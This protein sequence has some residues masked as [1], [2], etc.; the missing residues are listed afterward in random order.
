MNLVVGTVTQSNEVFIVLS[1]GMKWS[2]RR[3]HLLRRF[4][5]SF[6]ALALQDLSAG[7]IEIPNPVVTPTA[8]SLVYILCEEEADFTPYLSELIL[9][10]KGLEAASRYLLIPELMLFTNPKIVSML[11]G[12]TYQE[13]RQPTQRKTIRSAGG[14]EYTQYFDYILPFYPKDELAQVFFEA[15]FA[16]QIWT[17]QYLLDHLDPS[18]LEYREDGTHTNISL[19]GIRRN[20]LKMDAPHALIYACGAGYAEIVQLLIKFGLRDSERGTCLRTASCLDKIQVVKVLLT[21]LTYDSQCIY[22][23]LRFLFKDGLRDTDK[24]DIL[25]LILGMTPDPV[26]NQFIWDH[27]LPKSFPPR[28][29]KDQIEQLLKFYE[30]DNL[31]VYDAYDELH[32]Y[33]SS[34]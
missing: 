20:A 7:V 22:N 8:M 34:R 33:L 31:S 16:G 15:L 5:E 17:V 1:C 29:T 21:E 14:L 24:Q 28:A 2:F 32:D 26:I 9:A 10:P 27:A 4:P 12:H 3:S 13:L 25:Q 11:Q 6:L 30:D 23:G 18:K 19:A